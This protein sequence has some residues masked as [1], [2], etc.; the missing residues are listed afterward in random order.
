MTQHLAAAGMSLSLSLRLMDASLETGAWHVTAC[1]CVSPTQ[2][3]GGPVAPRPDKP[4]PSPTASEL[5]W[6]VTVGESLILLWS[7]PTFW[8]KYEYS[9]ALYVLLHRGE[10]VPMHQCLH[11]LQSEF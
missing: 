10:A 3:S 6:R 5:T 4:S 2:P 8:Q 11:L 9:S 1:G 7:T